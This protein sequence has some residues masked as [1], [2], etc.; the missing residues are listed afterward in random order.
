MSQFFTTRHTDLL[1]CHHRDDVLKAPSGFI[2]DTE[3]DVVLLLVVVEVPRLP[4]DHLDHVGPPPTAPVLGL[5][6]WKPMFWWARVLV[7]KGLGK[8]F[9]P[10]AN[11]EKKNSIKEGTMD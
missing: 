5:M 6:S 7:V 4:S 11:E 3:A 2:S 9:T 8:I 10:D 1:S